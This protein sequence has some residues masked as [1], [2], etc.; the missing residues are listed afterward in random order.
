[1]VIT[2]RAYHNDAD[3]DRILRFLSAANVADAPRL[4]Y[5][6]PGGDI[7][8]N[9]YQSFDFDPRA[10]FR[11]WEEAGEL[12]GLGWFEA[13][14]SFAFQVALHKLDDEALAE[15]L[16]AWGIRQVREHTG[17]SGGM[18]RVIA[19][20]SFP[21]QLALLSRHG[22][23]R[24]TRTPPRLIERRGYPPDGYFM[25]DFQRGLRDLPEPMMP[26][27]WAVRPVGG[28]EEWPARVELH[29]TVWAPSRITLQ[30]YRRLRAAPVYRPDL[31]FIAVAPDGRLA[32]YCICWL[33]PVTH[34]AE[35]EPVGTHPDFRRRGIGRMLLLEAFRR[36]REAGAET[37]T[38]P[39][40]SVNTPAVRLYESAGF[41]VAD[42]EY[43]YVRAV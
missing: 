22:F 1:M 23:V 29:R 2:D 12:V 25:V 19:R 33:D 26:P 41:T 6:H 17:D 27:G 10:S 4:R 32:A 35:F 9:M 31:D 21:E 8:W 24:E 20:A 18:L 14:D 37:A 43:I 36:L 40:N 11:L 13:P 16:L 34:I 3:R 28:E 5:W 39:T 7:I 15:A 42:T 38:V 30:A